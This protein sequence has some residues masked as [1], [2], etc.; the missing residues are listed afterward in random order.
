VAAQLV[1]HGRPYLSVADV[2]EPSYATGLSV[3][4]VRRRRRELAF[5]PVTSPQSQQRPP[6]FCGPFPRRSNGPAP[7]ATRHVAAIHTIYDHRRHVTTLY[8][9]IVGVAFVVLT[10]P[11]PPTRRTVSCLRRGGRILFRK[12]LQFIVIAV[13]SVMS[14]TFPYAYGVFYVTINSWR[15]RGPSCHRHGERHGEI[16]LG[17]L[18]PRCH[19]GDDAHDDDIQAYSR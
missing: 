2:L 12:R 3:A 14:G 4:P 18:L 16:G 11:M 10:L 17:K 5:S 8:A 6:R 7:E 13:M 1:L 19:D 9:Y 15:V